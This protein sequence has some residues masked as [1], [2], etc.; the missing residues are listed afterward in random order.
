MIKQNTERFS[1]KNQDNFFFLDNVSL[2]SGAHTVDQT[3]FEFTEI[4]LSLNSPHV[5][6]KGVCHHA[7]LSRQKMHSFTM[8]CQYDPDISIQNNHIRKKK[9]A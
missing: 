7:H 9:K 4:L 2:C 1:S 5:R 8:S 3:G 6:V